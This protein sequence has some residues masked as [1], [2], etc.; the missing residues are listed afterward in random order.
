MASCVVFRWSMFVIVWPLLLLPSTQEVQVRVSCH[1]YLTNFAHVAANFTSCAIQHS[2]PF[3]FCCS[4]NKA[5]VA[6]LN[7]HR[8]IVGNDTCRGDLVM[9]E[10]HQIVESAYDFVVNLWTSS[11]C[12]DCFHNDVDGT[13]E[14]LKPKITE[15]FEKWEAVEG[16][17]FNNSRNHTIPVPV[18]GSHQNISG[19]YSVCDNCRKPYSALEEFYKSIANSDDLKVCADVSA[20]MNYTRQHWSNSFH[21]VKIVHDLVSVVALTVFFC[22]LPIIFYSAARLQGASEVRKTETMRAPLT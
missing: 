19:V 6:V 14:H 4:C 20:S 10:Q 5:Y 8:A 16:C 7:I 9:G 1:K 18:N 11:H 17:F 15:F 22:F 2:R 12:P 13:P 3:R 21:C